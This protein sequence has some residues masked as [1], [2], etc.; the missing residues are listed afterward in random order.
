MAPESTPPPSGTLPVPTAAYGETGASPRGWSKSGAFFKCPFKYAAAYELNLQVGDRAPL[1][2]GTL[3]H[4]GLYSFYERLRLQRLEQP[5]THMPPPLDAMAAYACAN[6][7]AAPHL[8]DMHRVVAEYMQKYPG[9]LG[10]QVV[11]TEHMCVGVIGFV[12]GNYGIWLV[13]PGIADAIV[14]ADGNLPDSALKDARGRAIIAD[15]ISV[16]GS[17]RKGFAIYCSRRLDIGFMDASGGIWEADHKFKARVTSSV[18]EDYEDDGQFG[19]AR[20]FGAQRWGD[21]F[22]GC[23]LNAIQTREVLKVER[24]ILPAKPIPDATL[25][26][27]ISEAEQRRAWLQVHRNPWHWP[28]TRDEQVCKGRYGRCAVG[29]SGYC[30]N[31]ASNKVA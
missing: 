29:K 14:A 18:G 1:L 8:A 26:M 4:V 25:P 6:P 27:D 3:G 2:R 23:M 15:R 12:E 21:R 5:H 22:R 7:A 28:R 11:S 17:P 24:P 9:H 31:G 13:P 20:W 10:A 30:A 19:M 16:E